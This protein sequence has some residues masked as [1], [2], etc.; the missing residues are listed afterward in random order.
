ISDLELSSVDMGGKDENVRVIETGEI[1]ENTVEKGGFLSKDAID[2]FIKVVPRDEYDARILGKGLRSGGPVFSIFQDDFPYVLPNFKINSPATWYEALD[3]HDAKPT[4]WIFAAVL[5]YEIQILGETLHR[6]IIV[7]TLS[8]EAQA[9]IEEMVRQVKYKRVELGYDYPFTVIIDAKAGRNP[10]TT[11]KDRSSV[12]ATWQE[13]L[14]DAGV[15]YVDLSRSN[16]G[17]VELGYK[18][19]REYLRPQM[20]KIHKKE[21][22]GLAFMERCR[23]LGADSIISAMKKHRYRKDSHKPEERYRDWIDP[24]RYLLLY[25]P[26]FIRERMDWEMRAEYKVRNRFTG[27]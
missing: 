20:W 21:V 5:P 16:P 14:E 12:S 1:W 19:I 27:R 10:D 25:R 11:M 18:L 3:P 24:I 17:D 9:G 4:K 23:D 13:K 7:D 8:L 22:P 15:G 2:D 26:V 6:I